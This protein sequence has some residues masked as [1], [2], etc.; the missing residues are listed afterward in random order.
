MCVC[1]CVCMC[2]CVFVRVYAVNIQQSILNDTGI[3]LW[4]CSQM[5]SA[6]HKHCYL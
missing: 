3:N 4:L 5:D 6:L 1:V 2:V